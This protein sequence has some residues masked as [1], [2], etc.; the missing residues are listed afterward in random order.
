MV[1]SS[2]DPGDRDPAIDLVGRV[3]ATLVERDL[4][5]LV[6]PEL[7]P[8]HTTAAGRRVHAESGLDDRLRK[9]RTS[10]FKHDERSRQPVAD[11]GDD[12]HDRLDKRGSEI[13]RKAD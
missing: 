11:L 7:V 1:Q 4:P 6:D 12:V 13:A 3:G 10:W 2:I 5:C 9:A 8:A